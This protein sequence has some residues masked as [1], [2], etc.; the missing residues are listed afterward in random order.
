[1]KEYD[2]ENIN[3]FTDGGYKKFPDGDE[4]AA[5][6]VYCKNLDFTASKRINNIKNSYIAEQ[7]AI[8]IAI[9]KI[10]SESPSY[11]LFKIN[12]DSLSSL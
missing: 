11:K 12:S 6:A 5:A 10:N 8:K 9:K 4:V 3:F 1:M 2:E 7:R